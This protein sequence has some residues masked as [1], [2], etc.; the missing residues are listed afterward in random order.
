MT[1]AERK[2]KALEWSERGMTNGAIAARLGVSTT[3]VRRYVDPDYDAYCKRVSAA[4][5]RDNPSKRREWD[6]VPCPSCK[7]TRV[8]PGVISCRACEREE[9]DSRW[10]ELLTL[11]NE[12]GLTG[13]EIAARTGRSIAAVEVDLTRMRKAGWDLKRRLRTPA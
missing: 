6:T 4:Y 12:E 10:H 1:T 8:E 7:T 2:A 9:R 13:R 5:R 3:T 11:W